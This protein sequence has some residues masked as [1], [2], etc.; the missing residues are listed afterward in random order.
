MATDVSQNSRRRNRRALAGFGQTTAADETVRVNYWTQSIPIPNGTIT[1][2]WDGVAA[3]LKTVSTRRGFPMSVR[4][5][6][7]TVYNLLAGELEALVS[8]DFVQS[9]PGG[10]ADGGNGSPGAHPPR[11]TNNQGLLLSIQSFHV[12]TLLL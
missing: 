12:A 3:G 7:A 4:F 1:E 2:V 6:N 11:C 10:S 9:K 8:D 5:L